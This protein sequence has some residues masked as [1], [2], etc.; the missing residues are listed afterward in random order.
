V[1]LFDTV[2]NTHVPTV[3]K[4]HNTNGSFHEELDCVFDQFPK[5]H[6]K[7][8]LGDFNEKVGREDIFKPTIRNKNLHKIA[9]SKI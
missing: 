6:M 1:I 7:I 9:T 3:D 4:S 2:L 5:D 8:L